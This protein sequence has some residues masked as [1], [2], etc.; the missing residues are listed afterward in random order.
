MI[1][2]E[3][4]LKQSDF[5][6]MRAD[7]G[8]E[9]GKKGGPRVPLYAVTRWLHMQPCSAHSDHTH[10]PTRLRV[11]AYSPSLR[12]TRFASFLGRF[13]ELISSSIFNQNQWFKIQNE[14]RNVRTRSIP[15][16]GQLMIGVDRKMAWKW[17]DGLGFLLEIKTGEFLPPN[18]FNVKPSPKRPNWVTHQ[19][20]RREEVKN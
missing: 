19:Q 16:R 8:S 18:Y 7:S 11:Q 17:P 4:I 5:E 15:I 20:F 10:V 12:S 2:K 9:C 6:K 14:G 3:I 1:N 13:P